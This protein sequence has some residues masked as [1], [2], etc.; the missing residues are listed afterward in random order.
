MR[1]HFLSTGRGARAARAQYPQTKPRAPPKGAIQLFRLT[2]EIVESRKARERVAERKRSRSEAN[3]GRRI[4]SSFGL[5][6]F[7]GREKPITVFPPRW[8]EQGAVGWAELLVV[9][10]R[11][12]EPPGLRA[13]PLAHPRSAQPEPD[14]IGAVS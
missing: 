2:A 8:A 4:G 6:L 10:L 5:C 9:L 3:T 1:K 11:L 13:G 7:F 14:R 12:Y